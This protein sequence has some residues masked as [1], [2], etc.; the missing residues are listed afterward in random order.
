MWKTLARP[1][2]SYCQSKKSVLPF[3]DRWSILPCLQDKWET[4]VHHKSWNLVRILYETGRKLYVLDY[5]FFGTHNITYKICL[6]F[7]QR[8][9]L[10]L[11]YWQVSHQTFPVCHD[12]ASSRWFST[13]FLAR[14]CSV[15]LLLQFRNTLNICRLIRQD[16]FCCFSFLK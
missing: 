2:K 1:C 12:L 7:G 6:D 5:K 16:I 3:I 11:G 15:C 8:Y 14:H 9:L 4:E 10:W 13:L